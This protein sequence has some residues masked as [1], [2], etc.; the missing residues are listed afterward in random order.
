MT[1]S[2]LNCKLIFEEA[3]KNRYTWPSTFNGYGGKCIFIDNQKSIQGDFILGSNFKPQIINISDNEIVKNI[4]H[5][6]FEVAIHRV[7]REFAE[8]HKN[9]N[10]NFLR[11]SEKGLEIEV[12][13]K[14]EGDKYIVKENKYGF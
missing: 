8:I 4:S 6:L 5:Q 9:N 1:T 10:F 12:I 13:G 7:K 11:E 14:N 3:Y 2:K